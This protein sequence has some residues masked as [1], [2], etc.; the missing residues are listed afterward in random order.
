M[1]FVACKSLADWQSHCVRTRSTARTVV[2]VGNFDG[3]H[4]G[5]QAILARLV[6]RASELNALAVVVTF[7]PHPLR[8]LRPDDAP[9]LLLTMDQRLAAFDRAGVDAAL[10][11]R[12]D[13][14]LS[15]LS[16]ENFARRIL[17]DTLR[18]QSILVGENFRFGYRGAGD[19]DLLRKLGAAEPPEKQFTV[20]CID[21]VIC[22]GITVSS[23]AIREAVRDGNVALAGRLLGRPFSLRG[24]IIPGAGRGAREVV[25]TLNLQTSQEALPHTGVYATEVALS[26]PSVPSPQTYRAVTNV[27]VRPTFNGEHL[28]IESYLFDFDQSLR[29]GEL[30]VRFFKKLRD[31]MKFPSPESLRAQ[32]RIDSARALHFFSLLSSSHHRIPS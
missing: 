8:L 27:G 5:H 24:R 23:T 21:P 15:E 4:L 13:R 31:E 16:P 14:T 20:E 12:F 30:E 22:R 7:D 9:A 29:S 1:S 17:V 11:L 2:T 19:V 28:S 18:A 10:V 32:I 26:A 3:V 6:Q 25:P